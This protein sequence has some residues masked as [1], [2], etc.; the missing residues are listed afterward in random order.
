MG[1]LF[2]IAKKPAKDTKSGSSINLKKGD[3]VEALINTA[4]KLVEEKLGKYKDT[5]RCVTDV[6]D[7][8]SFFSETPENG[9]MG[10]DTETTGLNTFTDELVGISLCNGKQAIYIP[11]NHKS[12]VFKTRLTNQMEPKAVKEIFGEVFKTRD[13]K[14]L[15]HNAKFDIAVLRTFFGYPVPNPYW[16]TMLAANLLYQDEEHGLKYLYNKYVA[17]EDEGVNRF[18]TLFKGVTFDF[19]P[20]DVATIY[21][22]KD[23]YM[24]LELYEYQKAQM[25]RPDFSGLKYVLENIEMPLLPILEDMNRTGVNI[26]QTM[27]NEFYEKYSARLEKAKTTVYAELEKHKNEIDTFRQTHFNKKLDDPINISSPTQLGVL[28]YEILGYKTKAG[29]GTGMAELEEIGSPLTK[30]LLEFRKME[31]LIDAFLVALPKRIEPSTG[32]I[33]T[34]L[35]QYG[36]AT[37]RFSSSN[38][39]LQQ[40]P[41]RGEAKELRR[42]FGA[43]PRLYIN[44]F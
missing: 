34:S 36:A 10:I 24:T 15:Y 32:K 8:K 2:E 29:K 35:N 43:S 9:I 3:T 1:T 28:F 17:M 22:G 12:S 25:D 40:I 33:H 11:I 44:V 37:G 21:A 6:E 14:W 18:D 13:F 23:A 5:S 42:I 7:L 20:L 30:A 41:S 16:D 26:N 19:V 4:R 38:P 27:L 31:K 39:N